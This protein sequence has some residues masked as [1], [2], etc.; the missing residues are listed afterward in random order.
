MT[1]S[2]DT[3]KNISKTLL[4]ICCGATLLLGLL[5]G[6]VAGVASTNA[7]SEFLESIVSL[8]RPAEID[9]PKSVERPKFHLSYP[10]NWE[11]A[12][13]EEDYDPDTHFSIDSPGDAFTMFMIGEGEIDPVDTV[14]QQVLAFRRIMPNLTTENFGEFGQYS[15]A[16]AKMKGRMF[17][18]PTTVWAYSFQHEGHAFIVTEQCADEDL[19]NVEPGFKLIRE[20]F[21][22]EEVE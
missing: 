16:A 12:D 4:L 13:D 2:M 6:F 11:V 20:S 21:Q 18:I 22:I 8:E 15:A 3:P 19:Q 5:V 7:G 14:Q 17:G 9:D 1:E 10:G